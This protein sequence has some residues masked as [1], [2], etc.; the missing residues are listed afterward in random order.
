MNNIICIS[1]QQLYISISQFT[2]YIG[3]VYNITY[4]LSFHPG[5]NSE[6]MKAAGIDCTLMFND[7]SEGLDYNIH[8]AVCIHACRYI[9]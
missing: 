1:I 6:I 9:C 3:D 8:I 4:Y 5:G 7:V 2:V